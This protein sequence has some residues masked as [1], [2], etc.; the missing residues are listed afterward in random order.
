[1]LFFS[2]I[3]IFPEYASDVA[4]KLAK[5]PFILK[6]IWLKHLKKR[7]FNRYGLEIDSPNIGAH[8]IMGHPLNITVN[9]RAII[10][11]DCVVFKNVTI[12][13]VRSGERKGCPVLGDRVVVGCGAF[14]CGGIK[15]GNDVLIAANSFVDFDVPDHSLV[16]G[17]PGVIHHKE[18]ATKDY[19]KSF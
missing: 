10:G 5:K 8:F 14:V 2:G 3:C 12:G 17:N 1:M 18:H 11:N 19:M 7:L 16:I 9:S 6:F 13:S 4:K 15:I